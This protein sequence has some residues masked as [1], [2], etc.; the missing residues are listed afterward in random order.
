MRTDPNFCIYIYS[1]SHVHYSTR[2][3]N[4]GQ[5]GWVPTLLATD[6]K[7]VKSEVKSL[8]SMALLTQPDHI[9]MAGALESEEP[10]WLEGS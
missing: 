5:T 7:Q 4:P 10:P 2:E 1:H 3:S 9:L 8:D 6:Q